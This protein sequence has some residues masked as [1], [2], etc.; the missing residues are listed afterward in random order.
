[1]RHLGRCGIA[2][3]VLFSAW[4]SPAE[5]SS[6][7]LVMANDN[8]TPAGELK[9]G[10]LNLRLELRQGRWYPEDEGGG[11]RD[12]YAY[13]E[14]GHA[15]QSSGPL[16]RVPQG[17]QIHATIH[18]TLPLP[19]VVKPVDA[20]NSL[21]VSLVRDRSGY[22]LLPANEAGPGGIDRAASAEA[23]HA[24]PRELEKMLSGLIYPTSGTAAVL[25]VHPRPAIAIHSQLARS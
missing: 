23:G 24:V 21:G 10:V 4:A 8:R 13:A 25:T 7:P 1:M 15:P 20:D 2:L 5:N 11:Y 14:E 6:L 17:T 16:I 22:R 18:N 19:V 3:L 12:V 9:N